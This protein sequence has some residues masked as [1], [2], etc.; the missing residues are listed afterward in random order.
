MRKFLVVL[1]IFLAAV[2]VASDIILR[3]VAEGMVAERMAQ[4]MDMSEE[5][6]VSIEGWAFLPQAVGGTYSEID[7]TAD[8]ATIADVTVEQINATAT[9]VEAPLADMLSQPSVTAGRVDGSFVVPYSYFNSHLPEGITVSTEGGQPRITG[10]LALPELGLST[11]VS[12][13]GEFT[14]DGDTVHVRPSDIQVGDLP[15]DVSG[16]VEGMLT[17]SVQAPRLPF[18]LEIT[19]MEAVS[20]GLRVTGTGQDIPLMGSESV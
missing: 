18:G 4:Q 8:N 16:M 20:S 2:V 1:L 15:V 11:T 13:V 7:I 14:V 10:E 9:D 19:E 6:D 17:F 5:P 3:G 12:A